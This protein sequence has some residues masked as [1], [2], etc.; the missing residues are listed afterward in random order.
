MVPDF[1]LP[2]RTRILFVIAGFIFLSGAVVMEMQWIEE[3]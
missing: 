1:K 3:W 2:V